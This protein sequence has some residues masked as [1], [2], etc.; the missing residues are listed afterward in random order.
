MK[1][2]AIAVA[3]VVVAALGYRWHRQRDYARAMTSLLCDT[4]F[5]EEAQEG[6]PA[7]LADPQD[8]GQLLRAMGDQMDSFNRDLPR[9][10]RWSEAH[11]PAPLLK[12]L[13]VSWT[14]TTLHLA[15]GGVDRGWQGALLACPEKVNNA[16]GPRTLVLATLAVG[17]E[18]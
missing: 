11:V 6:R 18:W 12:R 3:V 15:E 13:R 2:L 7:P 9:M 4:G 10:A 1:T 5:V 14:D 8:L 17:R 16:D